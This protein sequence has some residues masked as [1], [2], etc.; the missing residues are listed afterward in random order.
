MRSA[1]VDVRAADL[2]EK[3]TKRIKNTADYSEIAFRRIRR[4]RRLPGERRSER[5]EPSDRASAASGAIKRCE[6]RR[7]MCKAW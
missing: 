6:Y 2:Q 5:S 1:L 3:P 4:R 7:L